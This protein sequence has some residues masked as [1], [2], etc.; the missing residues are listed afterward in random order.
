MEDEKFRICNAQV[1]LNSQFFIIG[2]TKNKKKS[3]VNR[4]VVSSQKANA[5]NISLQ[6]PDP[7]A[8][9]SEMH[10]LRSGAFS[11]RLSVAD[12][13]FRKFDQN[14]KSGLGIWKISKHD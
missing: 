7:R 8:N 11:P 13:R 10:I 3:D 2:W 14:I 6:V 12:G 9:Q 5:M 4:T 1:A